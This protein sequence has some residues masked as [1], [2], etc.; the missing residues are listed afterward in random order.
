[1]NRGLEV[2]MIDG[3]KP[4]IPCLCHI[5]Y[6][7]CLSLHM[8]GVAQKLSSKPPTIHIEVLSKR[9]RKEYLLLMQ[10]NSSAIFDI[11]FR[12]LITWIE[13]HRAGSSS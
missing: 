2:I 11:H 1:M 8:F 3:K 4:Q 13:D 5:A 6:R 7:L 12:L 9:R 10:S